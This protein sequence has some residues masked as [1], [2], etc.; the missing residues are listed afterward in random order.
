MVTRS[1]KR[2]V[3]RGDVT[4]PG[5]LAKIRIPPYIDLPN[6]QL[7]QVSVPVLVARR[8]RADTALPARLPQTVDVRSL[9]GAPPMRTKSPQPG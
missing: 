6:V 7:T 1:M 5:P 8:L 3:P 2:V 4:I 9:V